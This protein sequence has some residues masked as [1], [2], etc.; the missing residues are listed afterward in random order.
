[1]KTVQY[2]TN[3][4][5]NQCEKFGANRNVTSLNQTTSLYT[6]FVIWIICWEDKEQ[7]LHVSPKYI[8]RYHEQSC[9]SPLEGAHASPIKNEHVNHTV[10]EGKP[11]SEITETWHAHV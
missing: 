3:T 7:Y 10:L 4:V 9:M 5:T 1:M 8:Y 11:L 6:F 2:F